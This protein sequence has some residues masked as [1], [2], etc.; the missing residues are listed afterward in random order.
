MLT[1]G[2]GFVG[3]GIAAALPGAGHDVVV[4]ARR[5]SEAEIASGHAI[6]CDIGRDVDPGVWL[7]RLHGIDAVV[8]C[9]GILRERG[10][11]TFQTVHVEAPLALFRACMQAGVRRVVQISAL[12]DARDAEFIASKH[13]CDDALALLNHGLEP[14]RQL[15]WTVLRPPVV[16]SAA[17]F[18]HGWLCHPG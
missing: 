13:R 17:G 8:N 7:P 15:V 16:Y 3:S 4:A 6:A 5:P 9:A 10:S 12:G 18:G 2:Q 11:D 14:A 1:G